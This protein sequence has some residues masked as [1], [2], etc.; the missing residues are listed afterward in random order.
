[1]TDGVLHNMAGPIRAGDLFVARKTELRWLDMRPGYRETPLRTTRV[2]L[3]SGHEA[4][5]E[6][7]D[8]F[9]R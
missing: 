2:A 8:L 1:M 5:N 3:T 9:D 6:S 7:S 4:L